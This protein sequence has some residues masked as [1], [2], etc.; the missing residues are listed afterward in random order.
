MNIDDEGSECYIVIGNLD[1]SEIRD[2]SVADETGQNFAKQD[3]WNIKESRQ[4]KTNKCGIVTK[5][6]GYELCWGLGAEG[7]RTYYTKYTVSNLLK[8]YTDADGFNYMFVA[9]GINPYPEY[10]K[11]I[12]QPEDSTITFTEDKVKVW[13]FRYY[14]DVSLNGNSIL[15]E[16]SEPF[17]SSSAMI[18]M[19]RFEKGMFEPADIRENEFE[20]I[21]AKAFVGSDYDESDEWTTEDT[22]FAIIA[23]LGFF[24]IPILV[25]IIYLIYIYRARKKVFKDLN[26]Y[27]DIPFEGNL[28]K[29]NQVLNAYSYF[30][31]DYNNLLSACILKLINLGAISITQQ[32]LDNGK[33]T[34][35]FV[36]G[37]LKNAEQLPVLLRK[38]HGIFKQAAGS[39]SILEPK[40]LK[41]YMKNQYSQSASDA[42]INTLHTKTSISNY[43]EQLDEVRHVFGLKKFLK[44]FSLIDERHVQEVSLW[45]DYMIFATLFGIADQ[46]IKDM[47]KINPEYFNM[48]QTARQMADD[49]T[50]PTI[51]SAMHS[52]A[53]RAAI[54]KAS[55][56]ARASGGGGHSSW[57]GGGGFSGGGHGGGVR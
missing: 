9:E 12:I 47:K 37:E 52:S 45:K 23:L 29:T 49:I 4:W 36:I 15:A 31:A 57:G 1:G 16:S 28:Q 33:T 20:S 53:S 6:N 51:Y 46:V 39:D 48:D 11:V 38:I 14:G 41:Y 13:G 55:R 18:L 19:C 2:F 50:L 54:D 32:M 5:H 30:S 42:F 25:F 27:R 56:E 43:K 8:G 21:R 10:V 24:G 7:N 17:S 40:E 3:S 34:E 26:W 22:I 44:D 35:N